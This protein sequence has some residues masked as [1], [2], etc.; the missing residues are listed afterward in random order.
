MHLLCKPAKLYL[1]LI[2]IGLAAIIP[3]CI[4]PK[5]YQ[6]GKPFVYS[7]NINIQ[8]NLSTVEKADLKLKLQ[9]QLDDSLKTLLRT[10]YPG[11]RQLVKPPVFDTA[12]A[13]RSVIFMN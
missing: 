2:I 6:P 3:G 4:I 9:N 1:L 13:L 7:T 5:K 12:A 10:I 8:G 11:R